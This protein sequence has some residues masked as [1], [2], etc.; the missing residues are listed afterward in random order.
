MAVAAGVQ[1]FLPVPAVMVDQV[2]AVEDIMRL[3]AVQAF[4]VKVTLVA[5]VTAQHHLIAM[6][7]VVV[8]VVLVKPVNQLAV[9]MV[10][11]DCLVQ[12]LELLHITQEAA[13]AEQRV[14]AV[15]VEDLAEVVM[16]R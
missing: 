16:V 2:V 1:A 6:A 14:V 7:V 10:A 5:Q 8:R 4:L 13:V 15:E 11:L 12:L 3:L 9:V